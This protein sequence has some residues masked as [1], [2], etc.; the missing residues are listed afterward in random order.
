VKGL[1]ADD[2]KVSAGVEVA[3]NAGPCLTG[4][5]RSVGQDEKVGPAQIVA[6]LE[7]G[8]TGED[9]IRT[10]RSGEDRDAN[11]LAINHR[12][13]GFRKDNDLRV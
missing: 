3:L 13:A 8:N 4:D 7:R 1:A 2:Q 5:G 12:K 10:K 6:L 11:R 9:R